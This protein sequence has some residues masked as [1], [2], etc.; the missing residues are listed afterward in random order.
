MPTVVQLKEELRAHG[1]ETQ[2]RKAVLEARLAEY[3]KQQEMEAAAE[4]GRE[5]AQE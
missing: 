1:L 5:V 4:V 2:G 3:L